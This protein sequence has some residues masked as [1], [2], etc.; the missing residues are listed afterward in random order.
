VV[1]GEE[2]RH[3]SGRGVAP[4]PLVGSAGKLPVGSTSAASIRR[5]AACTA[6]CGSTTRGSRC[7]RRSVRC[8]APSSRSRSRA[9][10][11]GDARR[12][13]GGGT[14]HASRPG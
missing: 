9:Q 10:H 13:L 14:V 4:G 6:T 2:V 5:P 8:A 3:R 1:R 11:Q 7:R 12:Q